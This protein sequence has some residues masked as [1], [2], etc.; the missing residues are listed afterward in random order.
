VELPVKPLLLSRCLPL[1]L[2]LSLFSAGGVPAAQVQTLALRECLA[3]ALMGNRDLQLERIN[4]DVASLQLYVAGGY[5]DPILF[6][7]Y[8]REAASE[9]GGFDPADFSRDTF[10]NADSQTSQAGLTGRLPTGMSYS[11]GGSYAQSDGDREGWN[12]S[13]HRIVASMSFSQP[14]LKNF[15]S[16]AGRL[17]LQLQRRNSKIG[18]LAVERI[19]QLIVRDTEQA[20]YAW[21]AARDLKSNLEELLRSRS[22]LLEA[23]ERQIKEGTA[24]ESDRLLA[25]SRVANLETTMVEADLA[26]RRAEVQLISLLGEG[27]RQ[28]AEQR[29]VP[30][31]LLLA[32]LTDASLQTS[33]SRGIEK[34]PELAAAE[35]EITKAGLVTRFRRNQLFPSLDVVGG[36]GRKGSS[37]QQLPPP[38]IADA[39]AGDAWRQLRAGDVPNDWLGVV[40]SMPLSRRAERGEFRISKKLQEQ[41]QILRER[42]EEIILR[43]IADAVHGVE[44]GAQRIQTSRRAKENAEAALVAEEKKL[45]GGK[46]TLFFVLQL[47]QDVADARAAHVRALADYQLALTHLHW[48]EG[49]LLEQRQITIEAR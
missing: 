20:Y 25:I 3:L 18:K 32:P 35:E 2:G 49:T 10:Y 31:E 37:T 47:Q 34:R 21:V 41:T 46:S 39:S 16:D 33:W 14:L 5:Y 1:A 6:G 40:F 43:E 28:R 13:S 38:L 11:L 44:S 22:R 24:S 15:W 45:T 19:A 12:F 48:S 17:N 7:Q 30:Q 29:M 36:Y 42:Q 4:S 27:F 8:R 26:I 9:M 23:T